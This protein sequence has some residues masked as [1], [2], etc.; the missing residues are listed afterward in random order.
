[1]TNITCDAN[2][3]RLVYTITSNEPTRPY[4]NGVQVEPHKKGGVLLVATDGHR[5]LVAHDPD[6]RTNAPAIV[7]VTS[8]VLKASALSPKALNTGKTRTLEVRGVTATVK[9][10]R[11][12]VLASCGDAIIDRTFPDWRRTCPIIPAA[13]AVLDYFN[14]T[15]V[16]DFCEVGV[17]IRAAATSIYSPEAGAPALVRFFGADETP[18]S[19]MFGVLMPVGAKGKNGAALPNFMT[20]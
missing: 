4:L 6:G 10:E 2:L 17:A 20:D 12:D 7:K 18:C 8:A 1:M 11:G 16:K 3:F 19:R 13:K 5:M 9:D 15:Y 14:P